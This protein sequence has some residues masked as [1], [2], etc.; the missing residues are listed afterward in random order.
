MGGAQAADTLLTL[1][2]RDAEKAGKPLAAA[3]VAA[4]RESIR[5]SYQEETDIRYGAARGWVDAIIRPDETRLWLATALAAIRP[6]D[7]ARSAVP[8][9]D[10]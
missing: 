6:E 1:R 3:E 10:V 7:L 2:L 8:A 9:R 5:G 4:L